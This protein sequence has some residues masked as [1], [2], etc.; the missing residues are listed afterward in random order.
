MMNEWIEE[1]KKFHSE[2]S[3]NDIH[4]S[5]LINDTKSEKV[6]QYTGEIIEGIFDGI[7]TYDMIEKLP[8]EQI[9]EIFEEIYT[10]SERFVYL[11]ISTIDDVEPIEWWI[12][13]VEKYAP[14][15]IYTH[16]KTYGKSNDYSILW[17]ESY[18]EWYLNSL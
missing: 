9:P 11:G 17:E 18:L 16:I 5:D 2:L 14:Q 7:Y 12:A 10:K 13:M 4:I 15:K 6:L 3:I 1:Y 8:K